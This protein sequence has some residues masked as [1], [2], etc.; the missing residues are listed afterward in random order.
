MIMDATHSREQERE[1]LVVSPKTEQR[2]AQTRSFLLSLARKVRNRFLPREFYA[3]LG[4]RDDQCAQLLSKAT[5][6]LQPAP[7]LRTGLIK[8]QNARE[9]LRELAPEIAERISRGKLLE[10]EAVWFSMR[11]AHD[12]L[13]FEGRAAVEFGTARHAHAIVLP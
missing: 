2:G 8:G 11:F 5:I 4:L 9:V 6:V 3:L 7:G 1:A 12:S 13:P 10:P